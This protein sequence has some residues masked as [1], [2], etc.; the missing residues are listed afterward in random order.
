MRTATAAGQPM[1][2]GWMIAAS[3]A[4]H[5]KKGLIM[6]ARQVRFSYFTLFLLLFA[7]LAADPQ[8][9]GLP[10]SQSQRKY[11]KS[12]L[13]AL[14]EHGDANAQVWLGRYVLMHN[15]S[16]DEAQSAMKWLRASAAQN[17]P[18]AEFYLGYLYDHG[19]F[20]PRNPTLAVENYAAAAAQHNAMAE[21]NL[22]SLYQRGQGVKKNLQKAFELYLAAA[23]EGNAVAQTNLANMYYGGHGV[24]RDYTQTVYWLRKSADAGFPDAEN[25]LAYFYY[26]GIGLQ[27]DYTEAARLIHLA[28]QQNLPAAETSLGYMYEQGKGVRLDYVAAY[29]WYSR[30][31]AG[32]D[33]TGEE[34]R[35]QLVRVMTRK[36]LDEANAL[37][38]A[39]MTGSGAPAEAASTTA[40]GSMSFSLVNH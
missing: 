27:Q 18:E 12:E 16:S 15:P 20:V 9:Q 17:N 40:T 1:H 11:T 7:L 35:K 10:Q 23:Q 29:S 5:F 34:H 30:A 26:Y 3:K 22:A 14:A 38:T 6:N 13:T 25:N 36:Q 28:V 8:A 32:G 21:N 31:V 37:T 4:R 24:A 19:E 39:A 2:A 33:H